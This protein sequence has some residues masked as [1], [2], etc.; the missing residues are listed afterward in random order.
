MQIINQAFAGLELSDLSKAQ[1]V[2][3][4][5]DKFKL[6]WTVSKKE[7]HLPD[8][9]PTGFY[10]VVRDDTNDVFTTVKKGYEPVQNSRMAELLVK[11]AEKSGYGIHNGGGLR[12]G[13]RVYIQL[14]TGLD[15]PSIGKSGTKVEGFVTGVNTHDGTK[16]LGFGNSNITIV[17]Q[18]TF[19]MA[20]S[21][22]ENKYRHTA[23][24]HE[25]VDGY[26]NQLERLRKEADNIYKKFEVFA[27][28]P[29]TEKEIE[30]IV[31]SITGYEHDK[32][33][34]SYVKN[35]AGDLLA[36]ISDQMIVHGETLWGLFSG[37]T[38]YTT[39][40]SPKPNREGGDI[41][42]KIVGSAAKADNSAFVTLSRMI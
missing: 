34:S 12:D 29:A 5:L 10:G 26:I 21:Q 17:C 32:E 13:A 30:L 33:N 37:V 24:I 40:K 39:H 41:E 31:K 3:E 15:I 11:I 9:T 2:A 42:S 16:S 1:E 14:K 22:V 35:R 6:R 38:H 27:E 4:L 18:N 8:G 7:L 20:Y 25:R 23:S 19:N 28:R 36:S